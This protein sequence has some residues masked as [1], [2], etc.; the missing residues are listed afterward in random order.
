MLDLPTISLGTN[1]QRG[2]LLGLQPRLQSVDYASVGRLYARIDSLLQA[3]AASGL[4][5]PA[6]IAVLPEYFGT[7]LI[8]EGAPPATLYAPTITAAM[9]PL[10]LANLPAFLAQR[11]GAHAPDQ[12]QETLFRSRAAHMASS[13]QALASRLATQYHITLVAGSIVLPA[14]FVERGILRSG[15]GPLVNMVAVYRPDGSAFPQITSKLF[16][17]DAEMGFTTPGQIT[18]LSVYDTPAGRLGVLVCAD[19]WYPQCY[20]ALRTSG[21]ELLAVPSYLSPYGVWNKPWGGYNGG[22]LPADIDP[23]DVGR[24]TEGQA[25]QKYALAGRTG[26]AGF[27]AAVNVFLRGKFWEMGT[28]GRSV[29]AL[30]NETLLGPKT[31]AAALVNVWL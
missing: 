15:D 14:P 12:L 6:T 2:N 17:I 25:W 9:V 18:D 21:A 16:P 7:W 29:A 19:S 28:D 24:I 10:I 27:H 4:L 1:H 26:S 20:T 22:I 23:H 11:R 31:D 30:G 13:Y 3:A 8:A 5:G